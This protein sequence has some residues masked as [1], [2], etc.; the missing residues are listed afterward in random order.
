VE[1]GEGTAKDA[2]RA[3][4]LYRHAHE[5][6]AL[7][8]RDDRDV[9]ACAS[10]AG[11]AY[12]N[13]APALMTSGPPAP[14][15]EVT[16]ARD[17]TARACDLD[18]GSACG[19]LSLIDLDRAAVLSDK[20]CRLGQRTACESIRSPRGIELHKADCEIGDG[21]ACSA[22]VQDLERAKAAAAEID[23]AKARARAQLVAG[24][25]VGGL[26]FGAARML[27]AGD[28]GPPDPEQAIALLEI[29]CATSGVCS[30]LAAS[31]LKTR[32]P[33]RR[34]RG[35]QLF[36]AACAKDASECAH[37]EELRGADPRARDFQAR[38]NEGYRRACNAGECTACSLLADNLARGKD[39]KNAAAMRKRACD[40]GCAYACAPA[41]K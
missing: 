15:E 14:S 3:A 23:A 13:A 28:G 35:V 38:A 37:A 39:A 1:L 7:R 6:D 8:C 25:K 36:D 20:A 17:M 32:D 22:V 9:L 5:I 2:P 24:C 33:A 27:E 12:L 19:M 34:A 11:W 31:L 26:C 30:S 21:D 16:F 41:K 10:I 40:L 18:V 4:R 29:P